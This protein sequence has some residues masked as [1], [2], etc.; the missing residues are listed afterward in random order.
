M[1]IFQG[2]LSHSNQETLANKGSVFTSPACV[3]LVERLC[4]DDFCVLL[5]LYSRHVIPPRLKNEMQDV[6]CLF[7]ILVFVGWAGLFQYFL[8]S[9]KLL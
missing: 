3:W 9:V 7:Q 4:Y 5:V 1:T 2:F 8:H 6:L